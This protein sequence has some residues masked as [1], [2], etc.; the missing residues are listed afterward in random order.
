MRLRNLRRLVDPRSIAV[1]GASPRAGSFGERVLANL[2]GFSGQVWAVNPKYSQIGAHPCHAALRELD[3]VPDCAVLVGNRDTIEASVRECAEIGVG[4]AIVFA[5]G[6]AETA[7]ADRVAQ[8]ARLAGLARESGVRVLG[9]NCMGIVNTVS[10]ARMTFQ[11]VAP[12]APGALPAIGLVCQSGAL[13]LGLAQA[14]E[15]GV[16]FSHVLTCG[17]A[18]DVDIA[19]FIDYL[20]ADPA[21]AAIA[22]SFEGMPE[23]RRLLAAARNAWRAGKALVVHKMATGTLGAAAAASHTGSLAGS[24]RVYRGML[25]QAGAVVVDDFGALV[26]TTS[27]FAKAPAPSGRGVAVLATSGGAAILAADAAEAKS[28]ALPQPGADTRAVLSQHVPEFGSVANPCD[29]TAQVVNNP[30]ALDACADALR[31]EPAHAAMDGAHTLI[32]LPWS[33]AHRDDVDQAPRDRADLLSVS[34]HRMAR[35]PGHAGDRGVPPRRAL[36]RLDAE[37]FR[38]DRCV[39]RARRASGR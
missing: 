12:P 20:V 35:G 31:A 36:F 4:A 27:F 16:A 23:P 22:C 32:R 5:S 19:D 34:T 28:V 11:S 13:G 15:R 10:G 37:L 24:H 8:Q 38:R 17:N 14:S 33:C 6:F 1:V 3:A 2:R 21:C 29:A 25:R 7:Q 26:E 39:V 9:P 18:C 30:D